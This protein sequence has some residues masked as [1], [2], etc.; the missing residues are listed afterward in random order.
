MR[1]I[2]LTSTI[3]L[4]LLGLSACQ[5]LAGGARSHPGTRIDRILESGELRVGVSASQPPLNMKSRSGEIIGLEADLV[6]ALARSMGVTA[7]FVVLPFAELLPALEQGALDIAVSGITITPERNA[8]VA[9]AGPYLISG[10]SLLTKSEELAG[11]ERP[12][13]LD[14]AS[15]SYAALTGST[16]ESFVKELLP[17]A[18]LRTTPDYDSAIQLVLDD[19][20]DAL[21][22]D[23]PICA[24]SVLRYPDA[25]LSRHRTPFTIEPLG[26]AL[27]ADDPL[28]VNLV[29]NYL[30]TLDDSGILTGLKAKWFSRGDWIA[31][32]P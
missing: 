3:A 20:V 9:F 26:I 7:R 23:F 4:C 31:E 10:K 15:R 14:D 22:A 24:L 30:R 25:G 1:R 5:N 16:S 11:A 19:E 8:R 27:P 17:K 29:E 2:I 6:Q 18:K 12:E 13:A 21:I 28:L 32:L